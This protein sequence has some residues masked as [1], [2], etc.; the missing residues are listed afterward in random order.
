MCIIDRTGVRLAHHP[1]GRLQGHRHFP[2]HRIA[3]ASDANDQSP[4]AAMP[5]PKQDQPSS[6]RRAKHGEK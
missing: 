1:A 6:E 4:Q 3:L 5:P 2:P